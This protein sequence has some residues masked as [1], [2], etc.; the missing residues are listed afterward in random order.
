VSAALIVS[1]TRRHRRVG[2]FAF[3][4]TSVATTPAVDADARQAKREIVE[5]ST[6]TIL[7]FE[8]PAGEETYEVTHDSHSLLLKSDF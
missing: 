4:L 8:A 7:M 6:C 1:A 2:M 3:V 5:A